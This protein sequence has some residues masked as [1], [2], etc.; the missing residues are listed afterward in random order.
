[1]NEQ[2]RQEKK[3]SASWERTCKLID[4]LA[5]K[6]RES[7]ERAIEHLEQ[8]NIAAAKAALKKGLE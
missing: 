4:Q 6:R 2:V 1:M 7:M 5:K 8:N 3:D